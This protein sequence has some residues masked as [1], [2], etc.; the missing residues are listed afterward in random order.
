MAK[1]YVYASRPIAVGEE[2]MSVVEREAGY[3]YFV[4]GAGNLLRA[5]QERRPPLT[6][7][8]IARREAQKLAHK[9][10]SE[11]KR[12]YREQ[13]KARVMAN[14]EARRVARAAAAVQKRTVQEAKVRARILALQAKL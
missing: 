1:E 6:A 13:V 4:D 8:E 7:E 2:M 14:K 5:K 9:A 10:F 12:A 3:F 11:K